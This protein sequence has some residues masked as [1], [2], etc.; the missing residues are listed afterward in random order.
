[1]EMPPVLGFYLAGFYLFLLFCSHVFLLF[2]QLNFS[3]LLLLLMSCWE[4]KQ[5]MEGED[6]AKREGNTYH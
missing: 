2:F 5:S 1:M 6:T 3:I 4:T